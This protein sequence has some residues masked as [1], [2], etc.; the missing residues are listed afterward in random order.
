MP[1]H[2]DATDQRKETQDL[3]F[4]GACQSVLVVHGRIRGPDHDFA[5]CQ[6]IDGDVF[7]AA[8]VAVAVVADAESLK[9]IGDA[10][11][12]E[13]DLNA[14]RLQVQPALVMFVSAVERIGKRQ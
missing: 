12:R 14:D 13:V 11:V 6:V 8:A 2:I 5:G 10:H 9:A 3:A 1:S 7:D 4:A